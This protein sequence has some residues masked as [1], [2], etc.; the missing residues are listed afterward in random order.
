MKALG[1]LVLRPVKPA[2]QEL[3]LKLKLN[4]GRA[5]FA[6]LSARIAILEKMPV[7]LIQTASVHCPPVLQLVKQD[8]I[9]PG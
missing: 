6:L 2:M 1:R 4:R 9:G 8:K 7:L 3:L 5:L